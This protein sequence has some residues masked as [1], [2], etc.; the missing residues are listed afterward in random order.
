VAE[1]K[2]KGNLFFKMCWV[3][4]PQPSMRDSINYCR[5]ILGPS[6]FLLHSGPSSNS[7]N[8]EGAKTSCLQAPSSSPVTYK[9]L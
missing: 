7:E 4:P 3:S 9:E 8:A 1:M 5:M 6:L 2:P